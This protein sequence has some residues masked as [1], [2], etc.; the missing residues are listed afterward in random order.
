MGKQITVAEA[1]GWSYTV[2]RTP[3]WQKQELVL[4]T[5]FDGQGPHAIVLVLSLDHSFSVTDKARIEGHMD[6][7]GES[8]WNHVMILFTCGDAL[9]ETSIEEYLE[10]SGEALFKMVEKCGNRYHVFDNTLKVN[11]TTQVRGLVEK[12]EE[13]V[14]MNHGNHYEIDRKAVNHVKLSRETDKERAEQKKLNLL[15]QRD[16]LRSKFG[17]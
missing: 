8:V 7:L 4:S 15:K 10:S 14:A 9:G 2:E 6:L 11:N 16:I 3:N 12:V 17:K 1:P 5:L 13:L